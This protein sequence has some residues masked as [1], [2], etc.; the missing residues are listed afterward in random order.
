[1]CAARRTQCTRL[2]NDAFEKPLPHAAFDDE[3][4]DR[5]IRHGDIPLIA[6]PCLGAAIRHRPWCRGIPPVARR[7]LRAGRL[8]DDAPTEALTIDL[9]ANRLS[10]GDRDA[11]RDGEAEAAQS[12]FK[13]AD[14]RLQI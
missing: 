9:D 8:D 2:I 3:T 10:L 6:I 13:I 4:V 12:G 11:R 5:P 14:V 7:A 1:M